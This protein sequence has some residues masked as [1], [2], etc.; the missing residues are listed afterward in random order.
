VRI[1]TSLSLPCGLCAAVAFKVTPPS[2]AN[3]PSPESLPLMMLAEPTK[4]A[5]KRLRGLL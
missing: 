1:A 5:T 2:V 4:S 3:R